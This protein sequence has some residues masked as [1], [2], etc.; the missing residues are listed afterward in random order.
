LN[1]GKMEQRGEENDC[2]KKGEERKGGNYSKV[3]LDVVADEAIQ[4][5]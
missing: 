4:V 1:G 5:E 2:G 3:G